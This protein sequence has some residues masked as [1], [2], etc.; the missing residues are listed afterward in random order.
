M[1]QVGILEVVI[2]EQRRD[3]VVVIVAY[4]IITTARMHFVAAAI[5]QIADQH[6]KHFTGMPLI[7]ATTAAVDYQTYSSVD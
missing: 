3:S 2:A 6:Q 7:K 4:Q 1:V 5:D